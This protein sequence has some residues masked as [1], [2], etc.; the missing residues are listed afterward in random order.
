MTSPKR[1]DI[2]DPEVDMDGGGN[3]SYKGE[4]FTGEVAEYAGDSLISLDEYADGVLHGKSQEWH[5]NGTLS[6][7]GRAKHGHPVGT[8]KQ[9]HPNGSIASERVFA[10]AGRTMLSDRAWDEN[11]NLTREWQRNTD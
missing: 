4:P 7:A 2:D 1:I 10:A 5:L 11:G 3:L 6:S 9:W 8:W